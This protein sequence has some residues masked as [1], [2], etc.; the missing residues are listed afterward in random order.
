M[1]TL[2]V[3][4]SIEKWCR[5][6]TGMCAV[7]CPSLVTKTSLKLIV[8]TFLENIDSSLF[9]TYIVYRKSGVKLLKQGRHW[10]GILHLIRNSLISH[11]RKLHS[12]NYLFLFFLL[13]KNTKKNNTVWYHQKCF[14]YIRMCHVSCRRVPLSTMCLRLKVAFSYWRDVC[15][16]YHCPWM[17]CMW[18]YAMT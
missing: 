8:V 17:M 6:F 13:E 2:V 1:W 15:L 16:T 4:T 7:C 3:E 18:F 14:V 5:F 9:S 12:E 11:V 10:G